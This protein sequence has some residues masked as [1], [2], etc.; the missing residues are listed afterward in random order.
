MSESLLILY[1][2]LMIPRD[3]AGY[4]DL[5]LKTAREHIQALESLLS[6]P[7][8]P[9]IKE[10]FRHV[11]SLKGSSQIMGYQEIAKS[12]SEIIANIRPQGTIL[13]A[14]KE[15]VSNLSTLVTEL[16]KQINRVP[17]KMGD[18]AA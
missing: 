10:V 14:D 16:E 15:L 8:L 5:F 3:I 9:D 12:C 1:D 18:V 7:S 4:N 13:T 6:S 2:Y 11:H 17:E